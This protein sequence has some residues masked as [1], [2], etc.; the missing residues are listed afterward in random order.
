[1]PPRKSGSVG[2]NIPGLCSE[3]GKRQRHQGGSLPPALFQLSVCEQPL[4]ASVHVEAPRGFKLD[5][6]VRTHLH[7]TLLE[8]PPT[9]TLL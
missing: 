9:L 4:P 2:V 6:A 8:A 3:P 5:S 1:M 7:Q